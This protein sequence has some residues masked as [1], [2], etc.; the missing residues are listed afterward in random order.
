MTYEISKQIRIYN[1]ED[2][3]DYVFTTDRVLDLIREN[4]PETYEGVG[5]GEY[6]VGWNDG[7]LVVNERL[8]ELLELHELK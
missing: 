6:S 5:L 4:I 7:I 1:N 3:W 2:E 8:F